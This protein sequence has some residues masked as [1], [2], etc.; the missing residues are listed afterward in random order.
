LYTILATLYILVTL[1]WLHCAFCGYIAYVVV[2]CVAV[3]VATGRTKGA[4]GK[5]ERNMGSHG[6]DGH[7]Q[8]EQA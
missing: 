8:V 6:V 2:H 3:I 1:H 4:D 5:C 7:N